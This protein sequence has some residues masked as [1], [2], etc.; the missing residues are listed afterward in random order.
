MGEEPRIP[1][2]DGRGV[3]KKATDGGRGW[4]RRLVSMK[5]GGIG[6]KNSKEGGEAMH[7]A[8]GLII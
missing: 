6:G 7:Y 2:M 3:G 8:T 1:G 5:G 4:D